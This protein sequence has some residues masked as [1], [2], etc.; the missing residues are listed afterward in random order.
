[1]M[2]PPRCRIKVVFLPQMWRRHSGRW[3]R[4]PSKTFNVRNGVKVTRKPNRDLYRRRRS[5]SASRRE[6]LW[7]SSPAFGW[8]A[9]ERML[10]GGCLIGQDLSGSTLRSSR[11]AG[12]GQCSQAASV[13][14][15]KRKAF[16]GILAP[17]VPI[18]SYQNGSRVPGSPERIRTH[19]QGPGEV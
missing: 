4:C 14:A 7:L 8:A 9:R 1:M 5:H 17:T 10:C 15:R 6:N 19:D 12:L 13:C 11:L 18:M 2:H 3:P 16:S